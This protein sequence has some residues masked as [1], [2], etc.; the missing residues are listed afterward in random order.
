MSTSSSEGITDGKK[1]TDYSI[2]KFFSA[3]SHKRCQTVF[4][5]C[6]SCT[7]NRTVNNVRLGGVLGGLISFPSGFYMLTY[8]VFTINVP[9]T[10]R[11]TTISIGTRQNQVFIC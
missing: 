8:S 5:S 9:L 4:A 6:I 2:C 11:F 1:V 3:L 7:P 10:V